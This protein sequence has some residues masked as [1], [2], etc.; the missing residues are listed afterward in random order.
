MADYVEVAVAAVNI[1]PVEELEAEDQSVP[2]LYLILAPKGLPL[3]RLAS[4]ALDAFHT[5]I[6][7][8]NLDDFEF[9]AFDQMTW[10]VLEEAEGHEAYSLSQLGFSVERVSG[11]LYGRFVV[12]VQAGQGRGLIDIG[13]VAV[14]APS[15]PHAYERA[16]DLLWSDDLVRHGLCPR[17][18][19]RTEARD[20][21]PGTPFTPPRQV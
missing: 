3:A 6:S 11:D 4:A 17:F 18:V 2:G 8:G 9:F 15:L 12:Q 13:T 1:T 7:V 5:R 14:A 10:R 20:T 21:E 16:R 19:D